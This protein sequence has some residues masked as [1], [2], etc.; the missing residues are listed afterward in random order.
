MGFETTLA[1]G[2]PEHLCSGSL[3]GT[4]SNSCIEAESRYKNTLTMAQDAKEET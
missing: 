1:K 3:F 2:L 4:R